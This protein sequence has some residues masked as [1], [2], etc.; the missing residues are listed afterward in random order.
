MARLW[1][2]HRHGAFN[3]RPG[4]SEG[5][6]EG[7]SERGRGK[8]NGPNWQ[9]QTTSMC[10]RIGV[11]Q[12]MWN[13]RMSPTDD[14]T[15]VTSVG[16]SDRSKLSAWSRPGERSSAAFHG[17][18]GQRGHI[19]PVGGRS[20]LKADRPWSANWVKHAGPGRRCHRQHLPR[21]LQSSGRQWISCWP[22]CWNPH[23]ENVRSPKPALLALRRLLSTSFTSV[24]ECIRGSAPPQQPAEQGSAPSLRGPSPPATSPGS[25]SARGLSIALLALFPWAGTVQRPP[26]V[27]QGQRVD[28]MNSQKA[29]GS[30]H[31]AVTGAF[32]LARPGSAQQR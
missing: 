2:C 1:L 4:C 20:H 23:E 29:R 9:C 19:S 25:R 6:R 14:D 8:I 26:G 21:N 31:T 15:I 17:F 18:A 28:F 10:R 27:L 5:P 32:E 16:L 3:S 7:R 12:G 11:G 24:Q 22:H 30:A 13:P